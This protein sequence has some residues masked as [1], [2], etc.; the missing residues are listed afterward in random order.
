MIEVVWFKRDLRAWDHEPLLSACSSG[1]PVLPLYIIEPGYWAL[2][3]HSGRHY[4]FLLE[5]LSDL[6][7]ALRR[8]GGWLVTRTGD[9]VEVLADLH[10]AYGIACIHAHEETGLLWTY[11]RDRA[12]RRWARGHGVRF[13]ERRQFG[14]FRPHPSREGWAGRWEAMM[15]AE[16]APAPACIRMAEVPAETTPDAPALGLAEDVCP[17]RQIG[18]RRE[19]I[20]L[21]GEFLGGR[22]KTYRRA[23]SSPLEGAVACS[24]I[25]PFIALGCIS[26]RETYQAAVRAHAGCRAAGDDVFAAGISSFMSRLR[27][28]CHFTQ[29]LE[30]EPELQVRSL[31]PHYEGLRPVGVSHLAIADAWIAGQTGFPFLDACMRSLRH[32]GW[33]NFRMRSMAMAFSSYH[34]WQD[35]RVPSQKLARLFT[36]FEPG[37]HYPQVQMQ[38]GTTGINT[39]RIYN[40][41][42][43]SRDQ[44]PDG[45]FIRRWV[46]ELAGVPAA[47]IHE[48]WKAPPERLRASGVCLGETYPE[49]MVDHEVAAARA[50]AA[51]YAVRDGAAYDRRARQIQDRHGSRKS[52]LRPPKAPRGRRRADVQAAF[53]FGG[54][55]ETEAPGARLFRGDGRAEEG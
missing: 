52:G 44:D 47:L 17:Q 3:E 24:R 15:R 26:V 22:G 12:V 8:R 5:C 11:A 28:R 37:I 21:L 49:P 25:S 16:T 41:V 46:P 55:E 14:V 53:D 2:P 18:G 29:K 50:R 23:M 19:A 27:W 4:A 32:T 6:D 10:A 54:P 40:P 36:D 31:H 20:R 48:P 39:A 38:S 7:A 42:K 45:L 35:W 51:V 13:A 43:Q 34:L 33:L 1:R 9:A 30:D